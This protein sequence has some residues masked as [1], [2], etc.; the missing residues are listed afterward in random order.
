MTS[1]RAAEESAC[2]AASRS[3][4]ACEAEK[5]KCLLFSPPPA[6]GF[7]EMGVIFF[8]FFF[9]FLRSPRGKALVC[10]LTHN[11][12]PFNPVSVCGREERVHLSNRERTRL[13][14]PLPAP[15]LEAQLGNHTNIYSCIPFICPVCPPVFHG[16]GCI[17][18]FV[19]RDGRR[20]K[21]GGEAKARFSSSP[22]LCFLPPIDPSPVAPLQVA[23]FFLPA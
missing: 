21:Q 16:G 12:A 7:I 5:R 15:I 1:A 4:E 19:H 14:A 10:P 17:S 23:S 22:A 20:N 13:A 6:E 2:P 11:P 3:P 8:F 18:L 9:F